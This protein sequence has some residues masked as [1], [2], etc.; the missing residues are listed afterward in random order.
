M[1]IFSGSDAKISVSEVRNSVQAQYDT[2]Q[3]GW[4]PFHLTDPTLYFHK[5]VCNVWI[6]PAGH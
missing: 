3:T 1:I 2:G 5:M 4:V 6:K